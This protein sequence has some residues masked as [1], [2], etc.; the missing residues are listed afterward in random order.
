VYFSVPQNFTPPPSFALRL[1]VKSTCHISII[2]SSCMCSQLRQ[3]GSKQGGGGCT[4]K[5]A[6]IISKAFKFFKWYCIFRW[7]G[8]TAEDV[9]VRARVT[10]GLEGKTRGSKR[11]RLFAEHRT[12]HKGTGYNIPYGFAGRS[13]VH[14]ANRATGSF[15]PVST[16][17]DLM[18]DGRL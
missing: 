10:A 2:Y 14:L 4:L 5:T 11:C 12:T 16:F 6:Q 13:Y 7:T 18:P 3:V 15:T 17:V 8:A 9:G 1:S